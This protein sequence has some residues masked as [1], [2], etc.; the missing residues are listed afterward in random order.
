MKFAV[1]PVLFASIAAAAK[2]IHPRLAPQPGFTV[3]SVL[4]NLQGPRTIVFDSQGDLLILERYGDKISAA[5]GDLATQDTLNV[6]TV[7]NAPG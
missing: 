4:K 2:Q 7:V 5:F 1:I 6:T 3:Y